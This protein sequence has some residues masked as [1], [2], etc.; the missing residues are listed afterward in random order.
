MCSLKQNVYLFA[1][2][3]Y[4]LLLELWCVGLFVYTGLFHSL[5]LIFNNRLPVTT[6]LGKT[7]MV[8]L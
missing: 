2:N 4:L 1:V 7:E 8:L 5:F 6:S 3:V